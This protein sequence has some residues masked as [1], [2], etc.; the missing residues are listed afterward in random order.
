MLLPVLG[1]MH[2]FIG[3][4]RL[5][6]SCLGLYSNHHSLILSLSLL[7]LWVGDVGFAPLV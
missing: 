4:N 5:L 6:P 3:G 7:S 2:G 1:E